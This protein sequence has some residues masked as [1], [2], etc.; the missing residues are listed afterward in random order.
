MT[1]ALASAPVLVTWV[2]HWS[3]WNWKLRSQCFQI[4]RSRRKL[5]GWPK[6]AKLENIITIRLHEHTMIEFLI[7][8]ID[9]VLFKRFNSKSLVKNKG[10]KS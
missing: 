7:H 2:K 8:Q 3:L 9:A 10:L 4:L 1:K 6:Q 5:F